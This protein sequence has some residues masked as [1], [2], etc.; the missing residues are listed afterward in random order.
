MITSHCHRSVLAAILPLLF[1][2]LQGCA[3]LTAIQDPERTQGLRAPAPQ[4]LHELVTLQGP[5]T[6]VSA[7]VSKQGGA[8]DL[9]FVILDIDGRNVVNFS[10]AAANNVGLTQN[11]PYGLVSVNSGG[12]P[13]TLTIGFGMPLRFERELK[14]SVQVNEPNVVQ[15]LAN[16]IHG[17]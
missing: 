3:N 4:G 5:G 12:N 15:V 6:F 16:V 1:L 11:N 2:A 9:T 8:N 13:E 10:L 14:L 7:Q 17:S